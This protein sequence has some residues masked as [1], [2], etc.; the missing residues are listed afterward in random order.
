[1]TVE[2]KLDSLVQV[3]KLLKDVST[4]L[5]GD[6][7]KALKRIETLEAKVTALQNGYVKPK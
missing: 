6:L 4:S 7:Q 3:C 5:D 1:M 2:E